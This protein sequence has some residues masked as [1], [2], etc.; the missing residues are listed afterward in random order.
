MQNSSIRR[1][2]QVRVHRPKGGGSAGAGVDRHN[3]CASY[4]G[5]H[6]LHG[7]AQT[8]Q[9]GEQGDELPVDE[10]LHQVSTPTIDVGCRQGRD[11]RARERNLLGEPHHVR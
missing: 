4:F 11:L 6:Q 8:K 3:R 2:E 7:K 1:K 5:A 9:E 10:E